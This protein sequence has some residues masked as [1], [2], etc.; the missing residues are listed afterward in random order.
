MEKK[1]LIKPLIIVAVIALII[2]G[3][4]VGITNYM[5]SRSVSV[6][7]SDVMATVDFLKGYIIALVVLLVICLV[8][9]I[10]SIK[11]PKKTGGLVRVES[12]VA[13][14]LSVVVVLNM[15][16][17]GPEY[18]M[19]NNLLA[20]TYYLSDETISESEQLVQ[21]IADEGIVLLKNDNN[22]LPLEG[23]KK[24]N[25][26]GWSSTSPVYGGTGSGSVDESTCVSLLQGLTDAGFELNS[27]LT[28]FY[29]EFKQGRPD[30]GMNG[31]DWTIPEPSM[32]EYDAAGI[33][34]SAKAFSDTAV[35]VIARS[36]G[37]NADL[38]TS[39]T[40]EDTYALDPSSWAGS[41]GVRYTEYA[42]DV[43]PDKSYLEL[44]NREK[45]MLD[46]VCSE[47]SNVVVVYNGANAM[48]LGFVED[49]DSINALLWVA[50]PGQTG[51][52]SLGRIMNGT[53]NPSGRT[54]DTFVYDLQNIPAINYVGD[55]SYDY[56]TSNQLV[57]TETASWLHA[58]FNDYVEGIY[59]GYKFYE[60]AA[61][62]GLI[63]YDKTVQYPFGYGL[64]YTSFTQSI[65]SINDDGTTITLSVKVTNNG[66]VAGKDV[67]EVYFNPPYENGGIE[68]ASANLIQ[69]A[70]T[71]DIQPG[72]SE[73]VEI[74]FAKED[75][76][77]YDSECIKSAAGAYVLE[78]GD[79][80]ISI[81]SD[82]H[83]I[84]DSETVNVAQ[85]VIYDD[86]HDG[87]RD[88]D[89][90]TATNLFD[91]A[92]GDVTYLSRANGF[93]NY[94]EAT[95]A[96]AEDA[97]FMSEE[98]AA[99][100]YCQNTYDSSE[101]DDA[102]TEMPT[103]GA[104]NGLTIKDMTDVDYNDAKWDELLDELT[105]DEMVA[106]VGNGGYSSAK[107][108]SIDLLALI[109]CDG[110]AAIKNNYSG[111]SGTAYPCETMIA[112]TWSKELATRRG[113]SMGKQC[114]DMNVTGWYGPAMDIH[115]TAYS[116]RNF[117]YYSE[118]GVLSGYMGACEVAGAKEYNVQCYIKHFALND[119]ETNRTGMLATWTNEQAMR[120]I[121]LK[122][123][124]MSVKQGG[125]DNVM[126]SFN[127][128]GNVWAGA[129]PELLQ[130]VL[131]GEW[132]FVGSVVTDWFNGS[133][134]GYMMADSAIRNGGDK[135]LSSGDALAQATNTES[136][137]TVNALREAS[138]NLLYSIANSNAMNDRNFGTPGWIKKLYAVDAVIIILLALWEVLTIR[139]Y[140]KKKENEAAI[141]E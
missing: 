32:D 100:F 135:M 13:A 53:V 54:V 1:K 59:V 24:L 3:A 55:L 84:L 89:D 122:S 123:F 44:S 118:D 49:Y 18:S 107:I 95:A 69:F 38:P 98:L 50:G 62:E 57:A 66:S 108:D 45:A 102:H 67:V 60:T 114:D 132:G 88:S 85:D 121:Y 75:L 86:S 29:T 40:D 103:T 11:L 138:H 113:E 28:D 112:A 68:K 110:P 79:Y 61:E 93:E 106:L 80:V 71:G 133:Y 39:I 136:A 16:V 73:I 77:S 137:G 82:S 111:Q 109:E 116:G 87:K 41:T 65:E 92:K 101:Y 48:E 56:F 119:S 126:S 25:V 105:V 115:R 8:A 37:E 91:Y 7:M 141:V 14:I 9:A 90:I 5:S 128:I 10:V 127:Y 130:T 27:D 51:F 36:G 140:L 76:A 125:A 20:D 17:L 15:V 120:E 74:A 97:Y 31:Q 63:D 72:E 34:D 96:P 42:D 19:L 35:V 70:K 58:T 4:V 43:A 83:T 12:A 78:A 124:E 117:E 30:V 139:N 33:F 99:S 131:R 46:R 21:D 26:F 134:D 23:T 64:S 22:A 129:N 81:N 6:S 104:K 94:E 47:F 52:E 2:V